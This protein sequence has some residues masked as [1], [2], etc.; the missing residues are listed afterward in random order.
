MW[1]TGTIALKRAEAKPG[2]ATEAVEDGVS[3]LNLKGDIFYFGFSALVSIE[4][5]IRTQTP[6]QNVLHGNFLR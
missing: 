6:I 5:P 1:V 2:D 4:E 3:I